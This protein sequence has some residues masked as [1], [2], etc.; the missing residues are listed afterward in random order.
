MTFNVHDLPSVGELLRM[1]IG[2][3]THYVKYIF[4]RKV[5]NE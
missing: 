2:I 4:A 5:V 1:G 3:D